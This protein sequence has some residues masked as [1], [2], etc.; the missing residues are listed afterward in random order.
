[1]YVCS[2]EVISNNEVKEKGGEGH[3]RNNARESAGGGYLYPK[4]LQWT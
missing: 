3:R 1:M 4:Y 2:D